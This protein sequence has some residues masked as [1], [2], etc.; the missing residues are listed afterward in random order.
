MVW[1]AGCGG[2]DRNHCWAGR[3]EYSRYV[4]PISAPAYT[5][6]RLYF[7][8]CGLYIPCAL[9]A[10][11]DGVFLMKISC[12]AHDYYPVITV[13]PRRHP[14]YKLDDLELELGPLVLNK[15]RG[16]R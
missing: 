10:D 4:V 7:S 16:R 12:D 14:A 15:C 5:H 9:V 2:S 8:P 3:Q 11:R 6:R 13:E 1:K